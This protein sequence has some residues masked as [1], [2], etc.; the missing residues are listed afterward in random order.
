VIASIDLALLESVTNA[1]ARREWRDGRAYLVAPVS[2]LVPGV[3]SGSKGALYYPPDEIARNVDAWD[4]VP[5]TIGHPQVNGQN[6]SAKAS[7]KHVG[8][9]HAPAIRNGKLAGEG[10]FDVERLRA[11]DVRVLDALERGDRIEVSTGL[12][13][14]N[15]PAPLGASHNGRPYDFI[16][17]NYRPDHLA[18]LP[19]QVGA[20]SVSDGCG[21]NVTNLACCDE[22]ASSPEPEFDMSLTERE[23]QDVMPTANLDDV[24]QQD[25]REAE[26]REENMRRLG[27]RDDQTDYDSR[28]QFGQPIGN[29][30][31]ID[32]LS[33]D[34][35]TTL[36][37]GQ[38]FAD[39]E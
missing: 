22:C 21:V 29:G 28:E 32:R 19:D 11:A 30:A 6:V 15:E 25:D 14:S 36:L 31:R 12:F 4:G 17:R 7:G 34:A 10:W 18:I 38:S 9:V 3:L 16:A 20:C 37:F 24:F 1:T 2:L 13:T 39:S 33:D 8:T 23:R 5:L 26:T 35:L 27:L